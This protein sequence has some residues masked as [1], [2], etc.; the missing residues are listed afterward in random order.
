[1]GTEK[2]FPGGP[3]SK[4]IVVVIYIH[5]GSGSEVHSFCTK[6]WEGIRGCFEYGFGDGFEYGFG[7]TVGHGFEHGFGCGFIL[8]A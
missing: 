6:I 3:R 8:S 4:M 7:D 5:L 1:M 2:P